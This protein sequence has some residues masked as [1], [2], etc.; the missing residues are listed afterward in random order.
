MP[1]P[2]APLPQPPPASAAPPPLTVP[3]LPLNSRV[4]TAGSGLIFTAVRPERILDFETVISYLQQAQRSATDPTVRAQA[5]GWRV[6][7]ATEAGPNSTVLYV[8]VID[9]VVAGADYGLG[10]I[11]SAAYPDRIMD[12]WKLYTGSIVQQSILNLSPFMPP[13]L[14]A[15][16]APPEPAT[17]PAP[18]TR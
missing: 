1:L 18:P 16:A 10:P 12:I 3:T 4:F 15:A 9:P 2:A 8:F 11:L 13:A 14:P 17:A 5:Q 6:F 7:K